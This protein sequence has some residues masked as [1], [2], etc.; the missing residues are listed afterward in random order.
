MTARRT[1]HDAQPLTLIVDGQPI[2]CT[3]G[4][5][6]AA[7][8][9]AS[10]QTAFRRD[11]QGRPRGLYCN[12]GSCGECTVIL[13]ANGRRVRACLTEAADGLEVTTLG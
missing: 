9:L 2:A 6:I 5:T 7:A 8:M 4:E 10:G 12:M 13:T 11:T 1:G 3:P